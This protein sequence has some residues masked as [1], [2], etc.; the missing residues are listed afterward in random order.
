M[1][2]VIICGN[3]KPMFTNVVA[4]LGYGLYRVAD[5]SFIPT[6]AE[7]VSTLNIHQP[8]GAVNGLLTVLP[9]FDSAVI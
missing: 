9:L 5:G 8:S 6:V 4:G 7:G 1:L 2:Q 3:T